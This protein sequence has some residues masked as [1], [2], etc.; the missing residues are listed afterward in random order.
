[1]INLARIS[2]ATILPLFCIQGSKRRTRSIIAPIIHIAFDA[3]RECGLENS[4]VEY[5][6]LLE[7]CAQRHPEQYHNCHFLGSLARN[8]GITSQKRLV[9]E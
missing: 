2:G 1:V 8:K 9:D 4:I 7:A 5:V 3:E 6:N